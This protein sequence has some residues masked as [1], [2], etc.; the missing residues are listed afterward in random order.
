[1]VLGI[2]QAGWGHIDDEVLAS[3]WLE[4]VAGGAIAHSQGM[5]LVVWQIDVC[6]KG[7]SAKSQEYHEIMR[8]W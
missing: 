4:E 1:M 5:P 2:F 7:G 6:W 8:R 3:V